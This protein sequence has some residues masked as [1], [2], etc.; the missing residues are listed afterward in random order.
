MK[1]FCMSQIN[2]NN[3]SRV[4]HGKPLDK[5]AALSIAHAESNNLYINC[6]ITPSV[7]RADIPHKCNI[8]GC[9]LFR[10]YLRDIFWKISH[11][12]LMYYECKK[13]LTKNLP[14][15]I[16]TYILQKCFT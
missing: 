14:D 10:L 15:D 5:D 12:A 11:K 6:I 2:F 16:V 9:P 3:N 13:V 8:E 4:I 7:V 1:Y